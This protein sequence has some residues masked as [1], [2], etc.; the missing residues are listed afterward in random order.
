MSNLE[1]S[2]EAITNFLHM[3]YYELY[4]TMIEID[5]LNEGIRQ[6]VEQYKPY[7]RKFNRIINK[8]PQ[9]YSENSSRSEH[10]SS[11]T[12]VSQNNC[13]ICQETL[14]KHACI[15]TPC[16]HWFHFKCLEEWIKYKQECCICRKDL[17]EIVKEE[18]YNFSSEYLSKLK[19]LDLKELCGNYGLS[20]SGNKSALIERLIKYNELRSPK[21]TSETT[22]SKIEENLNL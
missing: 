22:E 20:K 4:L 3:Y 10:G 21:I 18:E 5:L 15:K 9:K 8:C 2:D 14:S 7:T 1:D 17:S 16:E 19:I 11:E 6:S 13:P 12:P